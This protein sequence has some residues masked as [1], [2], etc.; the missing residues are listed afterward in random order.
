MKE[1]FFV[2]HAE[3]ESNVDGIYRHKDS[4]L[5]EKG[6]QQARSLAN[7]IQK[8][9][10]DAL[11]TTSFPRAKATANAISEQ[12]GLRIEEND[13]FVERRRPSIVLG[14]HE[15]DS[16]MKEIMRE[17][18]DGH[19]L[20]NHRHSDE[21]N[22]EDVR[23]RA[24]AALHF[25]VQHPKDRICVVTHAFFLRVLFAA[26]LN[27]EQFT[28]RDLQNTFKGL[29]VDNTGIFYFKHSPNRWHTNE[30]EFWQIISWNDS[31]HLG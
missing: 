4:D 31:A 2:R 18:Y 3:S 29:T 1:I 19:L 17:M 12:T 5:T 10:V 22:F 9:G 13:L 25:L 28:G 15:G 7:R 24:N 16:S 20:P 6:I 26:A 11:I 21:E 8:I 23:E 30:S 14:R 27:G